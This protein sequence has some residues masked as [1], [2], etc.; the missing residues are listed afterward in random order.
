MKIIN[1]IPNYKRILKF[2]VIALS[3]SLLAS[4]VTSAKLKAKATSKVESKLESKAQSKATSKV[5][6]KAQ[7][8]ATSKVESKA[9]NKQNYEPV[10]TYRPNSGKTAVGQPQDATIVQKNVVDNF[11][12]YPA[13]SPEFENVPEGSTV[14]RHA[15]DKAAEQLDKANSF[16]NEYLINGFPSVKDYPN[17]SN[18]EPND[19]FSKTSFGL[20]NS[21]G[22][23]S[24]GQGLSQG[25]SQGQGQGM[26]SF[27]G[28]NRPSSNSENKGFK[29]DIVYDETPEIQRPSKNESK[30][31]YIYIQKYPIYIY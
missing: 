28:F 21:D 15:S 24:Q 16:N 5:E 29:K 8:K 14:I 31:S 12:T 4:T 30:F 11:N 7:S 6:S 18:G 23:Q 2:I 27:A 3:L 26:N 25:L 13:H 20:N 10:T 22:Y 19:Y 9:Q 17:N 1:Q